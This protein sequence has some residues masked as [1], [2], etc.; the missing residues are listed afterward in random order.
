MCRRSMRLS[1][2]L[3]VF[4]IAV[5]SHAQP[6]VCQRRTVAVSILDSQILPIDNVAPADLIGSLG[7]KSVK[8]LSVAPDQRPHRVALV[9]DSSGSMTEALGVDAPTHWRIALS[10]AQMFAEENASRAQL[11]LVIFN[12][13]VTKT[14]GFAEGNAAV[15]AEL[16]KLSTDKTFD[17]TGIN[18]RTALRDAVVRAT[19]LFKRPTSADAIYLITDGGDNASFHKTKD[20]IRALSTSSVRL[21]VILFPGLDLVIIQGQLKLQE[22]ADMAD[23]SGGEILAELDWHDGRAVIASDS[24]VP[25]QLSFGEIMTRLDQ[26]I[27]QDD[28]VEIELPNPTSKAEKWKLT[29]TDTAR[30][31]W[32]GAKIA[33][34]VLLSSCSVAVSNPRK[35]TAR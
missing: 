23:Y 10:L 14:I 13:Q 30:H 12:R 35:V 19:Q 25:K 15:E 31:R 2:A 20:V 24:D 17:E 22:L 29:L 16:R 26:V 34:P 1:L 18:G 8:I 32:R 33:Y 11:A 28:L 6:L 4:L 5:P 21:F 27:F 3:L 9:L 7:K